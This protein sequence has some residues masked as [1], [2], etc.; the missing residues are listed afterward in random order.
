MLDHDYNSDLYEQ[1]F[2]RSLENEAFNVE[3]IGRLQR[4]LSH[5]GVVLNCEGL[6]IM[7]YQI[8]LHL[9]CLSRPG[10]DEKVCFLHTQSQSKTS[11]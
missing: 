2:R 11:L 3:T 5:L 10:L 1:M 8:G 7:I 4:P 6:Y 9:M